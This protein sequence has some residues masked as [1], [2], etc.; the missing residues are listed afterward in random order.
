MDQAGLEIRVLGDLEVRRGGE[1]VPLPQSRKTRAL[2]A[3]LVLNPG[4]HRRERLCE[5]FWQVPD[6]PRGSLRWSLSKLRGLVDDEDVTRIQADRNQVA[7]VPDRASIDLVQ[8]REQLQSGLDTLDTAALQGL[9]EAMSRGCMEGL[10]ISGQPLFEQYLTVEREA[11]RGNRSLVLEA[12]VARLQDQPSARLP[13]L[14]Q[15]L[16]IEPY[17]L[18]IHRSLIETLALA[19]LPREAEQQ[20]HTTLESLADL[21]DDQRYS[22]QRAAGLR[23]AASREEVP[24][25]P[26]TSLHQDIRFCSTPDG[27]QLAYAS[28]GEGPPL[29]KTANWLNHLEFDWESPVWRHVFH[30]LADGRQLV[31]YDARGNGLSEWRVKSFSFEHQVSD[32][33]AVVEAVGLERFD[34]VGISQGAAVSVEFAARHPEHVRSLIIIGGYA[35]G[36]RHLAPEQV[37][38]AEAMEKLIRIGWGQETDAFRQLFAAT[39][40][41]EAPTENQT[42]FNELQRISTSPDNAADLMLSLGEVDVSER[43]KEVRAPTLVIHCRNDMTAPMR[44][45]RELAASIP[46]A[47]FVSLNSAN[48]LLPD[49]DPAWPVMRQEIESFLAEHNE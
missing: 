46:G 43:L 36:W 9:A 28:V 5:I 1:R 27:L 31:R 47:R 20:L 21:D 45:A 38:Q 22:L 39:F 15:W 13:W 12:L 41:P 42:W 34:L 26:G 14:Q 44:G 11:A 30:A 17:R 18:D 16:E 2:L 6:D 33:E 3:Y 29:V 8:L 25:P 35:R 40:M 24:V 7:F 23:P 48:H 32:L 10:D 19:G 4:P 49:S 37:E